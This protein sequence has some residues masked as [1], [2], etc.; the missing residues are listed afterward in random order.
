M[1][2]LGVP[3]DAD[4]A[5]LRPTSEWRLSARTVRALDTREQ[6]IADARRELSALSDIELRIMIAR[7][8]DEALL[9]FGPGETPEDFP[10]AATMTREDMLDFL[11]ETAGGDPEIEVIYPGAAD[12]T[13]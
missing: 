13:E 5:M 3:Q 4:P 8:L 9:D 7:D 2:I 12:P 1:Y 6:Q 10:D 11:A